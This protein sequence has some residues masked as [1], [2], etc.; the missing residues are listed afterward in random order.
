[1]AA[2]AAAVA[3]DLAAEGMD[4]AV[5]LAEAMGSV[6]VD[7]GTVMAVGSTGA[8]MDG[9]EE[10]GILTG[11]DGDTRIITV[12]LTMVI[13]LPIRITVGTINRDITE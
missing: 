7:M 6:M 12:I 5:D 4:L 10:V 1:M 8:A 2:A 3:M 9:E 13:T 11:A